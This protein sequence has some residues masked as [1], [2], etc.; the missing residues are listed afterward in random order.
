VA[1]LA[2]SDAHRRRHN[3]RTEV[4]ITARFALDTD[5]EGVGPAPG[6]R[7]VGEGQGVR[8]NRHDDMAAA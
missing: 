8:G 3:D 2:F 5:V 7:L 4:L 1:L 6:A